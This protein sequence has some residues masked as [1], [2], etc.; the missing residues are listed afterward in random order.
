MHYS[1]NDKCQTYF[2]YSGMLRQVTISMFITLERLENVQRAVS[3]PSTAQLGTY[4]SD[5]IY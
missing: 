4:K 5:Q 3:R 1:S 2:H